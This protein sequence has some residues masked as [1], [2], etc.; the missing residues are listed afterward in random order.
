M[1]II[2]GLGNP[3]KQY[4]KTY[5]NLGWLALDWILGEVK[6]VENKKFKALTF[7]FN[8]DLYVKPLTYMN[9]S[10]EAVQAVLAYYKID[11]TIDLVVLHDDIDV[12]FGKYK[13]ALDSRSAGNNGVQSIIDHLKTKN[14]T[15]VRL[16]VRNE[17]RVVLPADKFVMQKFKSSELKV[18]KEL[19]LNLKL[20]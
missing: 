17:M 3:G 9:N 19:V 18:L 1:K 11:P 2:V 20:E 16:G 5:H 4:E 10:G 13:I 15:R 8:G 14:F 12:D 6:W 7:E